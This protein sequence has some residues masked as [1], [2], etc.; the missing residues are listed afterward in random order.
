[1]IS[2]VTTTTTTITSAQVMTYSVIAVATLIIFLILR[3]ILS[4]EIKK[5]NRINA[6]VKRSNIA[7]YPLIIVFLAI[8]GYKMVN[9]I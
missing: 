5:D 9:L 8:I 3:E 2:T 1:M 7:I 6:F 4:A